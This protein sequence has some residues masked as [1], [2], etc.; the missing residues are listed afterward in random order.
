[1]LPTVIIENLKFSTWTHPLWLHSCYILHVY[2][3]VK[4]S[5]S[6]F[7]IVIEVVRV[8][9]KSEHRE[10]IRLP[11]VERFVRFSTKK[12]RNLLKKQQF[13]TSQEFWDANPN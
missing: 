12:R 1:M 9:K 7:H 5:F 2:N 4:S 3:I 6:I 8:R 11:E 10:K 13:T